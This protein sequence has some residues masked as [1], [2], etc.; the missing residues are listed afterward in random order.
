MPADAD[1]TRAA[2]PAAPG[3]GVLEVAVAAPGATPE[4]LA[5][6]DDAERARAA[7]QRNAPDVARA[8]TGRALLRLL[9]A[10]W[11]GLEARGVGLRRECLECG[12]GDHGRPVV[13]APGPGGRRVHV[14][15]SHSAGAV[16]AVAGADGPV[17]VDVEEHAGTA[18]AG[19][20]DLALAPA[21]RTAL[22]ALP[23]GARP[24]ARALWWA[25]KEAVLKAT[26]H[27]LT[28]PPSAL[29]VGAPGT[30]GTGA[31][32]GGVLSAWPPQLD[33]ALRPPAH[34][35]LLDLAPALDAVLEPGSAAACAAVL[36]PRAPRVRVLDPG[37]LDPAGLLAGLRGT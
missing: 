37:A 2:E 5:L 17:G 32:P 35:W 29:V 7:R 24:A 31:G 28:V 11:T 12:P 26:G 20:D 6:L 36:A 30:G 22:A 21:E 19:F 14:S 8:V 16:L 4:V 3:P 34:P 9:A 27:G 1:T 18:F 33:A 25:R 10:R 15:V 23:E 13:V